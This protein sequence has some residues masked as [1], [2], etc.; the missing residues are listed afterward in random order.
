M[1]QPCLEQQQD[2]FVTL[3]QKA[4]PGNSPAKRAPTIRI[5]ISLAVTALAPCPML[6][7]DPSAA[8]ASSRARLGEGDK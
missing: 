5:L 8:L 2:D 6:A 1:G 4:G 3:E 7:Y